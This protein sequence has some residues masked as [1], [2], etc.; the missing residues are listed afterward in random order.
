MDKIKEK[1]KDQTDLAKF[2]DLQISSILGGVIDA[3][4]EM[5]YANVHPELLFTLPNGLQIFRSKFKPARSKEALCIGGPL[6]A[7]EHIISNM[8]IKTTVRFLIHQMTY[9]SK[10]KPKLD[11]FPVIGKICSFVDEDIEEITD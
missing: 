8:G 5:K 10:Y 7:I 1:N 9:F 3:L 2:K 11:Y 6:G 4:I